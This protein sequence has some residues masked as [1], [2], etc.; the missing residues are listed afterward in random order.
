MVTIAIVVALL[1][2]GGVWYF[3]RNVQTSPP[4]T[5]GGQESTE[6]LEI[7]SQT[8]T[9][10]DQ[11][12]FTF[13][14]S[15]ALRIDNHPEDKVNYANIEMTLDGINGRILIMASD[16]TYQTIDS[17]AAKD[18]QA[19]LAGGGTQTTLGGKAARKLIYTETN[20]TKIAAVDEMILFSL[21][22]EPD[23]EGEMQ[24]YYDQIVA[25]FTFVY[26]TQAQSSTTG[27]G[28]SSDIIEEEEIIE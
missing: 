4:V 6:S 8:K 5:P 11:A 3:S 20:I 28:S 17:W 13:E 18:P 2:G 7:P 19:K 1:V 23:Q 22:L 10:T 16:T 27:G 15:S 24:K 26:P 14:Y 21:D 12:G 25:S 9:W